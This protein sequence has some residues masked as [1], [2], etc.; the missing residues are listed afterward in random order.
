MV[1]LHTL[2]C[3]IIPRSSTNSHATCILKKRGPAKVA[4]RMSAHCS[5]TH[6]RLDTTRIDYSQ[7]RQPIECRQSLL[8]LVSKETLPLQDS[9]W[10]GTLLSRR[11]VSRLTRK[12]V[13]HLV[14]MRIQAVSMDD[15]LHSLLGAGR[16]W[17]YCRL[18]IYIT[19]RY[20]ELHKIG[21]DSQHSPLMSFI[22]RSTGYP[23]SGRS[24][25]SSYH[26]WPLRSIYLLKSSY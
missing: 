14:T 17:K 18:K 7:R 4:L 11:Y 8:A 24:T 21:T 5:R 19:S 26:A 16:L 10:C 12:I 2:L 13:I 15:N 6:T 3:R 22:I 23:F 20:A 25:T 9:Q 1:L